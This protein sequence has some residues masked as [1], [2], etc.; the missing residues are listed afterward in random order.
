MIIYKY[1]LKMHLFI[2]II[3]FFSPF[4]C[5]SS[6]MNHGLCDAIRLRLFSQKIT[7]NVFLLNYQ[8]FQPGKLQFGVPFAIIYYTGK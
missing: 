8:Y 2:V 5:L 6:L 7:G 3:L 1:Y 4:R